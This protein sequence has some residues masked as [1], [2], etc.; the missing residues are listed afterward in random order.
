MIKIF[1]CEE[2]KKIYEGKY[3]NRFPNTIQ[4]TARRKLIYIDEAEII[5]DLRVPPGNRLEKLTGDRKEQW[6]IRINQRYR[7]C[8]K[9]HVLTSEG[10]A[11]ESMDCSTPAG[12]IGLG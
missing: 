10:H 9:M 8:F 12:A 7:I 1:A 4:R 6:S 3:S 11:F 5:E 2:T